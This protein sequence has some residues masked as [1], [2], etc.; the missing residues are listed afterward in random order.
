MSIE[1][2]RAACVTRGMIASSQC[3]DPG[4]SRQ[5]IDR[6]SMDRRIAFD[7]SEV[8]ARYDFVSPRR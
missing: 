3:F 6:G 4:E 1:D 2:G 8:P 7:P 5:P